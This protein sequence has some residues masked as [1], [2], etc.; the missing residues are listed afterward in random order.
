MEYLIISLVTLFGAGLTL[1]SGFGLGT[2]LMP[3]FGLFFPIDIAIVLTAIVHFSNN[4]I[5]LGFFYKHLDWKIILRFGIPSVIAA[6]LGAYLLTALSGLK[7]IMSYS[8]SGHVFSVTPTK[9]TIALLLIF[10]SLMELVPKLAGMQFD[11][12]YMPLGGLLSGFFGGLSGN[13]GALRSAFLIRAGLSKETFI[14]T[15]VVI[16]CCI[17]LSRL[18]VYSRSI[19]TH[20]D[21]SKMVLLGVAVLS[22]FIGVY[23]GSKLVKKITIKS[24]QITVAVMLLIF[25]VLL[26]SGII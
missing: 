4:L 11:K 12:K 13:Q 22:A 15:G 3:V 1:F 19:L 5:K 20:I 21:H 14:G 2:L 23:F 6:L 8:I 26:G 25:S 18:A 7:P 9:L 17:D 10:F 16:A 24:L